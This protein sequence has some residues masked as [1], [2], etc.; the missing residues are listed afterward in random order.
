MAGPTIIKV[1][2]NLDEEAL[3][4]LTEIRDRLPAPA[5]PSNA[6]MSAELEQARY[7]GRTHALS[8]L[9]GVLDEWIDGAKGNH[10]GLDHQGERIGEECW[11]RFA[12]ADFRRMI[13]DAAREVGVKE[14][15]KPEIA[16]EDFPL[17]KW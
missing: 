4:L 13:N 7:Y 10:H 14:W 8:V 5:A 17:E 3:R 12:P 6:P 1:E 2:A 9:L 11:R 15:P 16:A